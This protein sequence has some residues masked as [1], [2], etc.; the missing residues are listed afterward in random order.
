MSQPPSSLADPG[1]DGTAA[2]GIEATRAGLASAGYLADDSAALV[3]HLAQRLGKPVLVE[4]PAGVGKTELAKQ[5]DC[6]RQFV[7]KKVKRI[8]QLFNLSPSQYMRSE[9]ACKAY[10]D[11]WQ[12]N[13]ERRSQSKPRSRNR[14][15]KPSTKQVLS[16]REGKGPSI[17]LSGPSGPPPGGYGGKESFIS[18][19]GGAGS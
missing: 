15:T 3:S 1:D 7:S 12:R 19:D 8:Q 9:A 10:A 13:H 5:R 4:G 14:T 16:P 18:N 2:G 17:K 11:A 6:S